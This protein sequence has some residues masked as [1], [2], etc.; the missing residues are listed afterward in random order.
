MSEGIA[1]LALFVGRK[2]FLMADSQ[3]MFES[4]RE[5]ITAETQRSII[6]YDGVED[7]YERRQQLRERYEELASQLNML[8]LQMDGLPKLPPLQEIHWAQV[9]QEQMGRRLAFL[10]VDTTGLYDDAEV[11]RVLLLSLEGTVLR[12]VFLRPRKMP[13]SAEIEAITGILTDT[14]EAVALDR[15]VWTGIAQDLP[16][17]YV[18]GYNLTFDVEQLTAQ[19]KREDGYPL[20]VVGDCLMEHA[21]KYFGAYRLSL[22]DACRRIGAPLPDRP[23]QTALHR[24]QGQRALL[25]A[26]AEGVIT[27]PDEKT[28]DDEEDYPF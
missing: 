26:M 21:S 18:L 17:W 24:A 2:R 23:Q 15:V 27:I 12:D 28:A 1:L 4:L 5:A 9:M 7:A 22:A 14:L 19:A 10:E 25:R 6:G 3:V 16:N 13:L 11:I 8:R 20:V